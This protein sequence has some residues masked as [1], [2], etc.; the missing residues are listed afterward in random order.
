[1]LTVAKDGQL[2]VNGA[3]IAAEELGAALRR[4]LAAAGS[5]TVLLRAEV[6]VE[7]RVLEEARAAAKA[8]GAKDVVVMLAEGR[9]GPASE[10]IPGQA[11]VTGRMDREI[12]RRV[13]RRH[14]DEVKWCYEQ[15][16]S[17]HPELAGRVEVR[18][19]VGPRGA[20]LSS[21]L[22]TSSLGN[23]TVEACIVEAVRRWEFPAPVGGDSVEVSYPFVFMP[24]ARA[25]VGRAP[26][27]PRQGASSVR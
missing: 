2:F 14:R 25:P 10:V 5:E 8:A 9:P 26:G 23:A 15:Q 21:A 1:M 17:K 27:P 11:L 13:I 24:T 16:L 4:A 19:T 3:R 22:A 20:V 7:P 12:V 18:F 6:T